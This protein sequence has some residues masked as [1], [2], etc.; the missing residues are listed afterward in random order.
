MKLLRKMRSLAKSNYVDWIML[1]R[2][3]VRIR[4]STGSSKSEKKEIRIDNE[5]ENMKWTKASRSV[6]L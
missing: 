5:I 6:Y 2:V 1:I 3:K 4:N